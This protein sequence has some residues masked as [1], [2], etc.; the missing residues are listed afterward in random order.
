MH[1]LVLIVALSATTGLCG[2]HKKT[3]CAPPCA[4]VVVAAPCPPPVCEVRVKK[5][6]GFKLCGKK[7][8]MGGCP[9]PGPVC[10]TVAGPSYAPMSSPQAMPTPQAPSKQS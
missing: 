10:E 3:R 7:K 5:H 9:T 4:P 2:G 1:Q 8:H 6:H